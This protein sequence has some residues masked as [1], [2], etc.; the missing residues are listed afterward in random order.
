MEKILTSD[1]T[2]TVAVLVA[3]LAVLT[4]E[5]LE[6]LAQEIIDLKAEVEAAKSEAETATAVNEELQKKVQELST[7]ADIKAV[8]SAQVKPAPSVEGKQFELS[9]KKYGFNFPKMVWKKTPITV[10]TV[11]ADTVLQ[12]ELVAANSSMIKEI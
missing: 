6:Q 2:Q 3:A 1:N 4:P 10:D 5:Q 8:T 11:L 9:G 7:A 12:A